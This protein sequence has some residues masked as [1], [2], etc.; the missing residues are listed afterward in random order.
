MKMRQRKQRAYAKRGFGWGKR[1]SDYEP[2]C[3]TCQAWAFYGQ[4]KRWPTWAVTYNIMEK[5]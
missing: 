5:S 4:H 2:S 1:C 3:I